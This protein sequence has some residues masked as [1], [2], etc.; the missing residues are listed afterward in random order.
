[1]GLTRGVGLARIAKG[2]LAD[3]WRQLGVTMQR[4]MDAKPLFGRGSMFQLVSFYH[5]DD[6]DSLRVIYKRK[7]SDQWSASKRRST[8][9]K[10]LG[11]RI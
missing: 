8:L 5:M 6:K 11:D 9:S 7:L 10:V 2:F 4:L 3:D 1:M